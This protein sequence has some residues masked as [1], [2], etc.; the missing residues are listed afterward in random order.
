MLC[1]RILPT[2]VGCCPKPFGLD[3][4]TVAAALSSHERGL[5]PWQMRTRGFEPRYADESGWGDVPLTVGGYT[6][7]WRRLLPASSMMRATRREKRR[8]DRMTATARLDAAANGRVA[9]S[10]VL[11]TSPRHPRGTPGIEPEMNRPSISPALC[12]IPVQHT[13]GINN[14]RSSS[15]TCVCL[16]YIYIT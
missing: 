1:R 13:P 6:R 3:R 15:C 16:L 5:R 9:T 7:R 11:F 10:A 2:A 12:P 4:R 8:V 14:L